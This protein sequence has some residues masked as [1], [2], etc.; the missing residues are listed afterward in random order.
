MID[1]KWQ[2]LDSGFEEIEIEHIKPSKNKK[3]NAV[4]Y[5]KDYSFSE[6][7]PSVS[8]IDS[9]SEHI[10]EVV[11]THTYNKGTNIVDV[12]VIEEDKGSG[13]IVVN[14]SFVKAVAKKQKSIRE[15]VA[16]N[17]RLPYVAS[18]L[19]TDAERQLFHFMM[20]ELLYKEKIHIFA[21][22][23]L[24]DILELDKRVAVDKRVYYDIA[25]KHVDYVITDI[26]TI[27]VICVVELHD[28]TH[29]Q[30]EVIKSDAFKSRSLREAGIPLVVIDTPIANIS[31]ND[32]RGIEKY[33]IERYKRKCPYCGA[34]LELKES[35]QMSNLGHRFLG[36]TNWKTGKCN[37]RR[38]I[39]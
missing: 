8:V 19:M 32:L 25:C 28:Y 31:K 34:E 20:N 7:L 26:E 9:G 39:D 11:D 1:I 33:L 29:N 21:K 14:D 6:Y 4:E 15:E 5:Y 30:K 22:V 35:R 23:R 37:Y 36:C 24:G 16:T 38:D 18:E 2:E 10:E 27:E 17:K 12:D 13:R 3:E